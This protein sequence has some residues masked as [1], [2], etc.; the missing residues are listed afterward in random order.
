MRLNKTLWTVQILLAA[1]YLFAGGAKLTMPVEAMAGPVS[2]PGP[3]LRFIGVCEVLGA[4]GL[5]LPSAL[6]ILPFLTPVAASGLAIIMVGATAVSAVGGFAMAI[7]P[8]VVG[9]LVAFV[10]YGR[11][12]V[13]P[14]SSRDGRTASASA[15]A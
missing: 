3:F 2:L 6:R 9:V 5:V 1:L 15:L 7:V 13:S 8:F 14:I 12:R 4:A 10:A 11:T